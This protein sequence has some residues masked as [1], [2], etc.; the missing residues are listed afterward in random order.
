MEVF[1][2]GAH[3]DTVDT[4]THALI[5]LKDSGWLASEAYE[6]EEDERYAVDRAQKPNPYAR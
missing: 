6:E 5:Y 3:D 1:P 2:N 4:L